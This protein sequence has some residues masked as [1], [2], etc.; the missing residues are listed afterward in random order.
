[1]PIPLLAKLLEGI[2]GTTADQYA[3]GS[4]SGTFDFS[5]AITSGEVPTL[6]QVSQVLDEKSRDPFQPFPNENLP[7]KPQ[8]SDQDNDQSASSTQNRKK[9][10]D[11]GEFHIRGKTP[12]APEE[13][14]EGIANKQP[15]PPE[16]ADARDPETDGSSAESRAD[17]ARKPSPTGD[18]GE[19]NG[20]R[21]ERSKAIPE[22]R[23]PDKRGADGEAR[24]ENNQLDAELLH[25]PIPVD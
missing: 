16:S 17:E 20:T 3:A 21:I 19:S 15:K 7:S 10:V 18:N 6:R 5:Q 2:G 11:I 9:P 8:T 23:Q 12:E 24:A 13:D 4:Y 14:Q 1:M 22:A 25:R